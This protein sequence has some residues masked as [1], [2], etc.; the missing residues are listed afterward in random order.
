MRKTAVLLIVFTFLIT[1]LFSISISSAAASHD[2]TTALRYSIH[3]FDANKC[4]P[5]AAVDNVFSWRGACHTTDG[6]EI[7][8]DLTGGYHDAG[9]HVKFGLPQ[10]YTAAILGWS[11]YEYKNVFDATGNT[12]KMLSTLK[13]FT[14][15]LLK[16]HPDANTFYYQVGDGQEDHTYWGA[17]EVQPGRRPVPYVANASNPASDVCGLTSAALTIMYLNYKDIDSNYANKCL[18]A[19][20]ELYNMGKTNLGHYAEN[21]FY[22]SHS[23]WDDLS[24]AAAWLYEVEK[25]PN[26]L[27]EIDSY[28][29][30]KTLWGESPFS[31]KWTMCW[32]DMYMG[33]FCKLAE[34]TGEQKYI[35][36]MNFNLDYWMNTLTTTPG[37][38]KYL[39][40]WGALRYAAAEAFIAMRYYELTGNESLKSFAKSQ[41]DYMLGSNPLNM[42]YVIGYGSKYPKCPHH[43]AANG[44]TYANGDNAKPAKNLLLGALVGGPNLS[45]GFTDDVNLYQHTEVALDYNAAFV[46][47]LAAM[48]KFSGNIII[49]TP[50]PTSPLP[51]PST[52]PLIWCDVGDLNADGSVNSIDLSYMRRYILRSINT[53]PYQE[54]DRIRIPAAD[55]NGDGAINSSDMSLLKRYVLRSITEFPVKY[56]IYG[57]I[58]K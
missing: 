6:S 48:E 51:T 18:K 45:D 41:I 24:F 52:T 3:F 14:D 29:S 21:A 15:Y 5:D 54:D 17:P 30:N 42:S 31:N 1:S 44:Y 23:Y 36:A 47:A 10:A 2:Y 46:G 55:M 32:D 13:Y 11:F 19:A 50:T 33:V 37:G 35:D 56:D 39:D 26:Y 57:N 20:K 58:I 22:I 43:R 28:L 49:P 40:S 9:D 38:L 16:C 7:G 27:K 12:Q 34:L 25:D 8:L 4:G 53:L